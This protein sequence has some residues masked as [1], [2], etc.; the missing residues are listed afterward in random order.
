MKVVYLTWGE[1][2]RTTGVF[3]SQVISQLKT[4]H[5]HAP[6]SQFW[7]ISGIPIIFSGLTQERLAY[8]KEIQILKEKL[9]E[10]NNL[11]L[12]IY[13]PQNFFYSRKL[14]MKLFHALSSQHL[15]NIVRKILPDVIHCRSY[16][17]T[18]AALKAREK[19]DLH[20][21]VIFDAR[22]L[23]PE[24]GVLKGRINPNSSDYRSMKVIEQYL[25]NESDATV[26]VSDTMQQHYKRLGSQNTIVI[27]LGALTN[28]LSPQKIEL[29][30]SH[31]RNR[32]TLC[33][34]GA[35]SDKTWHKPAYL[36]QLYKK[37]R[38]CL[39]NS[40]LLIITQ[41][42]HENIYKDRGD[43]PLSEITITSTQTPQELAKL[44]QSSR[45]GALPYFQPQSSI[46][47]QIA[48]T[49]IASKTAEYL[50]AGLPVL[51]N[52]SCGGATTLVEREG[53]GIGYSLENLQEINSESLKNLST[54][55]VAKKAIK[56]AQKNLDFDSNA[57]R[58]LKL[59][60]S[61]L[62]NTKTS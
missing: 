22:G 59:Y 27:Y 10:I 47:K 2:P 39:P 30:H 36:F 58:Y 46:E 6:E 19:S 20:Y 60:H 24:E 41:S 45:F 54:L 14:E 3:G 43:I 8:V 7:L 21:K 4:I 44:L 25:L 35:L 31:K 56:V 29:D 9:G 23:W 51:V 26:V 53:V 55:Q 48:N 34:V 16:H 38:N 37:Y 12:P 32:Y 40:K 50:A 42:N 13:S 49:V 28:I 5:E 57:D 52:Q 1:T 18:Y 17:A 15:I 62:R 33:Y 11:L 61:I